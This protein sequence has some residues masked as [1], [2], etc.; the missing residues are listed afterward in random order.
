MKIK[1][2]GQLMLYVWGIVIAIAGVMTAAY[3]VVASR[4]ETSLWPEENHFLIVIIGV[5]ACLWGIILKML[6]T[7]PPEN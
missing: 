2:A 7:D 1:K 5:L 3:G 6:A 4:L